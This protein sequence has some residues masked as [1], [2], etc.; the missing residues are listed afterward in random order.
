[1]SQTGGKHSTKGLP[2]LVVTA[3]LSAAWSSHLSGHQAK[4][5]DSLYVLDE[6]VE[7][8]PRDFL[9]LSSLLKATELAMVTLP[10]PRAFS[11][12]PK[13]PVPGSPK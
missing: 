13:T 4:W 8:Q 1:M 7:A 2:W 11:Q 9:I 5:V 12:L 3:P 10:P 6:Y